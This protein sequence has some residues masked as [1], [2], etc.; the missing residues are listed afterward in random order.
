MRKVPLSFVIS[1]LIFLSASR[2]PAKDL[3]DPRFMERAQAGF[4][5]IFNMDYD[6]ARKTF[7][8]LGKEYPQHPAPPLYLACIFWLE[9]MLRRQ[10]L[11]LNRFIA[12]TYFS[13]KTDFVMPPQERTAFLN[14]LQKSQ[15]LAKAI[16]KKNRSDMDARYFLATSYG[17]RSSFAITIDHSLREAFSNGNKA[18]SF[19]KQLIEENPNYYDAYLTV[20]IYEY[21]VG[22]I[23]WYLKWMIFVIGIRGNKLE[24]MEH[25]TLASEKGQYVK[26]EA[27]LVSMVLNVREH[28]YAEAL[29][30]ACFLNNRFPRSFL[31]PLNVAQILQMSGQ[32][33][34]ALALLL[35]VEKR[36]EAKDPNFDKLPLQSYR[37][38]L[39][40]DFMDRGQLD[41]AEERFRKAIS[42]P[43]T[44]RRE[45]AL[46]H[47]RLARLLDWKGR[48]SEAIKECQIVL[49]LEDVENSHNQARQFLK[50]HNQKPNPSQ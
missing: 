12:P 11:S 46:S 21:I 43:Q 41:L 16:L 47:L 14:N 25:L 7:A 50:Q 37:F 24:G 42:D 27:Q 8:A 6:Q 29:E 34:Q 9:E 2:L 17:L 13:G 38:N 49:S 33:E 15:D 3:R 31:F 36:A 30:I 39:G 48:Q 18:Y 20:G 23:P 35:Q 1:L 4:A 32:K 40:V 19:S 28:R 22:S 45:I 5:D 44:S 10:D 26:N